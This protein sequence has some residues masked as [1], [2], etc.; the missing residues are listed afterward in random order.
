MCVVKGGSDH[1]HSFMANKTVNL[2]FPTNK[3]AISCL[4]INGFGSLVENYS[5]IQGIYFDFTDT[6]RVRVM[7]EMAF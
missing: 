5:S 2:H 6:F 7:H 1:I 3:M 4:G